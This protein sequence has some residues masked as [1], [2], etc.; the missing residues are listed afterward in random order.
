MSGLTSIKI[1]DTVTSIGEY[2]FYGCNSLAKIEM[3]ANMPN[4]L[5]NTFYRTATTG[6]ETRVFYYPG[7]RHNWNQQVSKISANGNTDLLANDYERVHYYCDVIFDSNGGTFTDVTD[8]SN[9]KT[10]KEVW[11]KEHLTQEQINSVG[12]PTKDGK[13]SSDG[14]PHEMLLL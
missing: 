9:T 12:K 7:Y 3:P 8:G 11:R 14:I 2:A 5:Q 13:C 1:P 6:D 10:I 4:I